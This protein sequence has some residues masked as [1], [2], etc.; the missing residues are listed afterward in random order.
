MPFKTIFNIVGVDESAGDLLAAAAL[1]QRTGAHLTAAVVACVPPAPFGD[2]TGAA[3]SAWSVAWEAESKQVE[4]RTAELRSLLS[5]KNLPGEVIPLYCLRSSIDE[6]VARRARYADLSL[7]GEGLMQDEFL[8]RQVLEGVLLQSPAPVILAPAGRP[9]DL[10]PQTVLVAW[11]ASLEAGAAVR[12]AM[13]MLV[14]A[15][16]V[17][18]V[19]V[20]PLAESNETGQEPGADI[21]TFLARHGVKA[22]VDVIASGGHAVD[23]AL[24]RHAA[25]INADLVVMGGYGHSRMRELIFGGVTRSMIE[26][27]AIPVLLAH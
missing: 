26:K 22:T 4:D 23:D 5:E 7:I 6:E 15:A 13:E 27:P 20:D 1:C 18:I 19:L 11:N 24:R 2:I 21:A 3:Y 16:D 12:H 25:D 10:A 14:G 8:F 9:V 17:R